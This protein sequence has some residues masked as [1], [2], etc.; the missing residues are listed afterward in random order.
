M[1]NINPR[2][3]RYIFDDLGAVY[4]INP[5]HV[6][7][8]L[9]NDEEDNLNY[10]GTYFPRSFVESYSIFLNLFENEHINR[11][12]S[13]KQV[14]NILDIGSGTGGNLVGLLQVLNSTYKRKRIEIYS[15]DGNGIA[16]D[17]QMKIICNIYEYLDRNENIVKIDTFQYRFT[18]KDDI[19][20]ILDMARHSGVFDSFDIILSFK[21][22]NELYA[23]DDFKNRG[24]FK[25]LLNIGE[26]YLADEG[27]MVI[28]DITNKVGIIAPQYISV[29][30]N[31]ECRE[32]FNEK[33]DSRI[34]F[35]LPL[36]CAF[37][38]DNCDSD[39][40]FSKKEFIIRHRYNYRDVSKVTYK[41]FA[42]A[43][44]AERILSDINN[45]SRYYYTISE[46]NRSGRFNYCLCGS[47]LYGQE[48]PINTP[49]IDS[50]IL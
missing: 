23:V 1:L 25:A 47:F 6:A 31:N 37:W 44:L 9:S 39:N 38:H 15:F 3:E 2:L 24:T 8:N 48:Y 29:I 30:M 36:S 14:I 10:L 20:N 41:V 33:T 17:Y 7:Q 32:Y 18:N 46:D 22:A 16:L 26:H 34:G 4:Q 40:C 45:C 35:I 42:T 49:V 13:K 27:I 28:E 11:E 50:F 43:E 5:E 12:F 21:F 19:K